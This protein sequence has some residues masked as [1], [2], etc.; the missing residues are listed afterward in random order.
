MLQ[1][2]KV[3]NPWQSAQNSLAEAGKPAVVERSY[4]YNGHHRISE[5]HEGGQ[6]K[7]RYHYNALGQRI[8]KAVIQPD[9][10][11][12]H[13]LFQYGQTGELLSEIQLD[14]IKAATN[15]QS[16]NI[17]WLHMRPVVALDSEQQSNNS[18]ITWL[19]SDHLLTARMATDRDQSLIWRWHSDAFG[20]G[21]AENLTANGT[22]RKDE[23]AFTFNLRFPGQYYD[24]ENGLHYNYFRTYDPQQGRYIQS[25][26]IGL[27][28]GVNTFAYAGSS[29]MGLIDWFGLECEEEQ[30]WLLLDTLE[31]TGGLI[32]KKTRVE[33]RELKIEA[34]SDTSGIELFYVEVQHWPLDERGQLASTIE[35][36]INV[37]PAVGGFNGIYKPVDNKTEK[38]V[39]TSGMGV[40]MTLGVS[41]PYDNKYGFSWDIRMPRQEQIHQNSAKYRV[42]IYGG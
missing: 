6:L 20:V 16:Q 32:E 5:Y 30:P 2:S 33:A 23:A 17:V 15:G 34:Y 12:Q 9:G 19:H 26:P 38:L 24:A 36:V 35:P 22:I 31:G 39:F 37:I 18:Q 41:T 10:S 40:G 42:Y 29:P 1:E 8:H 28:G 3:E 25:D 4:R 14:S 7:A 11:E 21:Q 27:L 13:T